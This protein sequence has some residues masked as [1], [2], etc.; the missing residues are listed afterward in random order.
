MT[1]TTTTRLD[2]HPQLD[3]E[4]AGIDRLA[5]AKKKIE[6]LGEDLADI[7]DGSPLS[8]NI[9]VTVAHG[10]SETGLDSESTIELAAARR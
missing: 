2:L 6:K 1:P 3:L 8:L 4:D 7:F 5:R 10:K 9:Q